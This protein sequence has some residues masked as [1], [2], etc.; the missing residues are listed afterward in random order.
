MKRHRLASI[1]IAILITLVTTELALRL[2]LLIPISI[3]SHYISDDEAGFKLRPS[4]FTD[5][6]GFNNPHTKTNPAPARTTASDTIA[7]VGDSFTFGSYPAEAVFPALVAAD[8]E[9]EGIAARA[10]NLGIP[11]AGPNSYVGVMRSYLPRLKPIAVVATIY[12]GNDVMQGDRRHPPKLWFGRIV[13]FGSIF[14]LDLDHLLVALTAGKFFRAAER[15]WHAHL[16]PAPDEPDQY[17]PPLPEKP[18][19]RLRWSELKA[20]R[21]NPDTDIARGYDGLA[22]Y[23]EEMAALARQSDT[24]FLVVLAPSQAELDAD[25]RTRIVQSFGGNP[26]D[27]DGTLP[28]RR[29]GEALSARG[30]P[31][32]DL[33]PALMTAGP[34]NVYNRND[35]HWNRHGN[36]IVAG[37]IADALK[38]VLTPH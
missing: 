26:E 15:A 7:F 23:A 30:I 32:V 31:F 14:S 1:A 27:F 4:E 25:L 33:T 3:S 34:T 10:I 6:D 24:K 17:F 13:N 12:L 8:L 16:T 20:A 2:S 36:A 22:S 38:P 35:T 29:V 5:A 37:V 11:G 19:S 21:I 9:A 18:L 28:A